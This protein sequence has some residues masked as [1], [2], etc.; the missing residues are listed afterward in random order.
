MQDRRLTQLP[1]Q[2]DMIL[3]KDSLLYKTSDEVNFR[4]SERESLQELGITKFSLVSDENQ[5]VPI[6]EKIYDKAISINDIQQS[7]LLGNCNVLAQLRAMVRK[8]PKYITENIFELENDNN[9]VCIRL[10]NKK[11][12]AKF[13]KVKKTI[14][15]TE[16]C[17]S[18]PWVKL[19]E[20]AFV[21]H[22]LCEDRSSFYCKLLNDYHH[23]NKKLIDYETATRK[24][25]CFTLLLGSEIKK[26]FLSHCYVEDTAESINAFIEKRVAVRL[27]NN[28]LMIASFKQNRYGVVNDHGYEV[29]NVIYLKNEA[30]GYI[31]LSNPWGNNN[32]NLMTALQ[33]TV[34]YYSGWR[35]RFYNKIDMS[36]SALPIVDVNGFDD[37]IIAIRFRDFIVN[38]DTLS[39]ADGT[40]NQCSQTTIDIT[41]RIEQQGFHK[42][43]FSIGTICLMAGLWGLWAKNSFA[44]PNT[45][46]RVVA[47][48]KFSRKLSFALVTFGSANVVYSGVSYF[49]S[50]QHSSSQNDNE[51]LDNAP[52]DQNLST[53]S[54]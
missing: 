2:D 46:M 18:S 10:Y 5:L 12:Q 38:S 24:L 8:N 27:R 6:K 44:P 33:R 15:F 50:Y 23:K 39:Y 53:F 32:I 17:K 3:L 48:N 28:K 29:V 52:K 51:N 43:T 25:E 7:Y 14:V 30:E 45:L 4:Y 47:D 36:R 9:H 49:S 54:Y 40:L 22:Y 34:T 26:D 41:K 42:K 11:N 21:Q 20:K 37:S 19:L 35:N 16:G 31:L 13:Y 1:H